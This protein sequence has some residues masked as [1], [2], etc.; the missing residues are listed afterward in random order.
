MV[1]QKYLTKQTIGDMNTQEMKVQTEQQEEQ[2]Q[3]SSM[4]D[5][6]F[7]MHIQQL[8]QDNTTQ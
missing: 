3:N 6:G 5:S 1:I 4:E 7:Q 8:H 2:E